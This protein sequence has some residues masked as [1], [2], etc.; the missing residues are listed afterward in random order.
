MT[1]TDMNQAEVNALDLGA[2]YIDAQQ[3]LSQFT[4]YA[5]YV[6]SVRFNTSIQTWQLPSTTPKYPGS[7]AKGC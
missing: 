4:P 6:Q 5:N 7:W 2:A 1:K 3:W